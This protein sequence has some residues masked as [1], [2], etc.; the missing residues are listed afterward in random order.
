MRQSLTYIADSY[1]HQP[2]RLTTRPQ[3]PPISK[4]IQNEPEVEPFDFP[5]E[6][7]D[8]KA[9]T[10]KPLFGPL[11]W[12]IAASSSFGVTLDA[13]ASHFSLTQAIQEIQTPKQTT[14]RSLNFAQK[15]PQQPKPQPKPRPKPM[16]FAQK[17]PTNRFLLSLH[18][19]RNQNADY[20]ILKIQESQYLDAPQ[21]TSKSSKTDWN[22]EWKHLKKT[23]FINY[24]GMQRF[25]TIATP[26]HIIGRTLLRRRR[27]SRN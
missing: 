7:L 4:F 18:Q 23:G 17:P 26:A 16:N 25:G 8:E 9:P 24:C 2:P 19:K 21:Q 15:P 22:L 13:P 10:N 3:N 20:Q 1:L 6:E 11:P 27:K 14:Q 12:R 5:E